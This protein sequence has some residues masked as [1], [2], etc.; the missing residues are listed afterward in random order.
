[1]LFVLEDAG[2]GI[3]SGLDCSG[4]IQT[5]SRE[6]EVYELDGDDYGAADG[7]R[8]FSAERRIRSLPTK[9]TPRLDDSSSAD[10]QCRWP[11]FSRRNKGH[12]PQGGYV[13]WVELP[14]SVD[15]LELHRRALEQKISIAPG[16][17]FSAKQKYKNFIR[18]SCGLPWTEK[19][20]RAVA[21]L[22]ELAR[23]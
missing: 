6:P 16:P 17:I 8:G 5:A 15:S 22:G 21:T 2:S 9:D 1:M 11:L 14:R 10:E 13:L 3:S 7:D 4:P 20:D 19:I 12:R 18:L 23:Q